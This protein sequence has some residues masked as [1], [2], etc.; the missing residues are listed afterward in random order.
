MTFGLRSWHENERCCLAGFRVPFFVV[1]KRHMVR[2]EMP[3]DL[4]L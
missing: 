4:P 3:A 1:E 2:S